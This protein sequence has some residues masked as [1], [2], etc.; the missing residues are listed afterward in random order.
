MWT[1]VSSYLLSRNVSVGA[2]GRPS[3]WLAIGRDVQEVP[4]QNGVVVRTA[5]DLKLIKLEAEHAARV[6]LK[7][8]WIKD[9]VLT[10][11]A[12]GDSEAQLK[13]QVDR[14]DENMTERLLLSFWYQC[15]FG[16]TFCKYFFSVHPQ[17]YMRGHLIF[18]FI[19]LHHVA[20]PTSDAIY[21][22]TSQYTANYLTLA[23]I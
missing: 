1:C 4:N 12:Y 6:L 20:R 7:T 8:Q 3:L 5:D 11:C 13:V 16:D 14:P 15:C 18:D 19:S 23:K 22:N 10:C 9:T 17:V 21:R 2:G